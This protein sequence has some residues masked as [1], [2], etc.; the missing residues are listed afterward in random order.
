MTA[1]A[2]FA[3]LNATGTTVAGPTLAALLNQRVAEVIRTTCAEWT[4]MGI[5]RGNYGTT[6]HDANR[7]L[8]GITAS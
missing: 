8:T 5:R 7:T 2:Q 1:T 4:S 3:K 6:E